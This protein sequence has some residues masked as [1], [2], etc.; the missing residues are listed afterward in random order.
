M[1]ALILRYFNDIRVP[2]LLLLIL[3]SLYIFSQG[4]INGFETRSNIYNYLPKIWIHSLPDWILYI[5]LLQAF[6]PVPYLFYRKKWIKGIGLLLAVIFI[7]IVF[8]CIPDGVW[9]AISLT[10]V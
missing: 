8:I 6:I 7:I 4:A 9:R 5:A 2:I 3:I 1:K 10:N